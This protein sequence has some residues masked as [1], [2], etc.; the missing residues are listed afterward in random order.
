LRRYAFIRSQRRRRLTKTSASVSSTSVIIPALNESANLARN[1]PSVRSQLGPGDELIVVD[2]GSADDTSAIASRFG[3]VVVSE[4]V[5]GRSRA[6]NAG[7]RRSQGDFVVFLDADCTPQDNWLLELL[8]PFADPVVGCVA[9]EI[10]NLDAGTQ[11]SGYLARK[12]HLGQSGAFNHPFLPYA[13]TGNAA[14][15]RA[16]LDRIGGFDEALFAGQDADLTWRMLLETHY[17]VVAAPGSVVTHRQDLTF[18]A[19]LR[20]KRRHAE[21]AAALYKKYKKLR[22]KE[23]PPFKRTYWEYHSILKR[24]VK[25]LWHWSAARLGVKTRQ[26]DD[27]QYQLLIEIG[28][29]LGRIKGSI[30]HGVWYP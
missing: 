7:L 3:A 27:Q 20:Q 5:R 12:G 1:L 30:R 22:R 24:S 21:G 17:V 4:P 6:R 15:R 26:T 8:K 18:S 11:F 28:E 2:N 10:L 25:Y 9:G 19:F 23:V 13:Q 29:K 14:Y 16:V